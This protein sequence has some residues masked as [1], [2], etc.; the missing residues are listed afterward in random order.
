MTKE[1]AGHVAHVRQTPEGTEAVPQGTLLPLSLWWSSQ[2]SQGKH[3]VKGKVDEI[4]S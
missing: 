1:A 2:E 4:S 3:C